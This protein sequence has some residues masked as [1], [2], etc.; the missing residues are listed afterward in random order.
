V[1]QLY[2]Q[3]RD[4]ARHEISMRQLRTEIDLSKSRLPLLHRPACSATCL[5]DVRED[6]SIFQ[7]QAA[8]FYAVGDNEH[9][10]KI[11]HVKRKS[12]YILRKG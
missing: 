12:N 6:Q 8:I 4:L 11:L 5:A 7:K 10:W 2:C 3:Q 9:E 1:T